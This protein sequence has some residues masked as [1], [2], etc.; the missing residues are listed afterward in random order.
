MFIKYPSIENSYQEKNIAYWLEHAPSLLD[1]TFVITEKI[2]GA[3]LQLIF[4]PHQPMQVASRNQIVDK[5]FMGIHEVLEKMANFLA[6][7]QKFSNE[8]NTTV[9]L[10]GEFFGDNIQKGVDYGKEKRIKFFDLRANGEMMG[11]DYFQAWFKDE[12]ELIAPVLACIQGLENALSYPEVFV[13]KVGVEREGNEAEGIV[14][15]PI[16]VYKNRRGEIFYL[17]KKAAR[18]S[19]KAHAKKE[20]IIDADLVRWQK[21]FRGYITENRLESVF[22]KNGRI[23][24]KTQVGDY[25]KAL[26][27]DAKEDFLK[28]YPEAPE[29]EIK[30]ICNIGSLGAQMLLKHL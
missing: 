19:E 13:T 28:D 8:E 12:P 25:L 26:V 1:E 5:G 3:N 22:S 11:Q 29:E 18:F 20:V 21:V 24:N 30:K 10:Y 23:E 9:H 6:S 7:A 15:K 2:H 27:E 14:I 17:K 16:R 4:I